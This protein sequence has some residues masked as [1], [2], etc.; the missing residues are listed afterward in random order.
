[1]RGT[2]TA[3]KAELCRRYLSIHSHKFSVRPLLSDKHPHISNSTPAARVTTTHRQTFGLEEAI[4]A[5]KKKK[6][7]NSEI[8]NIQLL[9]PDIFITQSLAL[10]LLW[11]ISQQKRKK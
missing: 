10:V 11:S 8:D 6:K 9:S 1:M 4:L 3:A 7:L 2:I 5:I